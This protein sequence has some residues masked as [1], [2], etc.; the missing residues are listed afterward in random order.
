MQK[1]HHIICI[2]SKNT[3][4]M[5]E[6]QGLPLVAQKS[7]FASITIKYNPRPQSCSS[8]ITGGWVPRLFL[9]LYIRENSQEHLFD[10][11]SFPLLFLLKKK[12]LE[13]SLSFSLSGKRWA[14]LSNLVVRK[15]WQKAWKNNFIFLF[16][17]TFRVATN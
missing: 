1:V 4:S 9:T 6:K 15:I 3:I 10:Y 12:Q 13:N 8:W 5:E 2:N 17:S 16:I 7:H 11:S 14:F